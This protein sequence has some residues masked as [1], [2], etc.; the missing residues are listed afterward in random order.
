MAIIVNRNV[1]SGEMPIKIPDGAVT[2]SKLADEAVTSD[3]LDWDSIKGFYKS[4]SRV[5][6]T[7]PATAY[8]EYFPSG[9]NI[10]FAAVAGGIYTVHAH[11]IYLE[12]QDNRTSEVDLFIRSVSG[13]TSDDE[14]DGKSLMTHAHGASR[15]AYL[16]LVSSGDTVTVKVGCNFQTPSASCSIYEGFIE[17]R[18]LA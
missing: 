18:R 9:W 15:D 13:V 8:D 10:T 3:K 14:A 7:S 2:T 5:D 12:N 1:T 16:H 17:V 11:T 6:F 4:C